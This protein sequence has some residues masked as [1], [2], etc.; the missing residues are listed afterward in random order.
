MSDEPEFVR[1]FFD[2]WMPIYAVAFIIM[3]G[4]MACAL[5]LGA[6]IGIIKMAFFQ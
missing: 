1:T 2:R 6:M 4:L 5:G 3:C